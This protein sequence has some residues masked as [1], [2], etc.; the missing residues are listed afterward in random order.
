M[1]QGFPS[2]VLG[3]VVGT[4]LRLVYDALFRAMDLDVGGRKQPLLVVLDEAHRFLPENGKGPRESTS[5]R[6]WVTTIRPSPCRGAPD[7]SANAVRRAGPAVIKAV[8]QA[9]GRIRTPHVRMHPYPSCHH[10]T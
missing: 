2:E 9:T 1:S 4:L 10:G 3:T 7:R 6:R 8:L 5:D